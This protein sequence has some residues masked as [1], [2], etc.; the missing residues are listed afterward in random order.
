MSQI[1]DILKH[2]CYNIKKFEIKRSNVL[3]LCFQQCFKLSAFGNNRRVR[4]ATDTLQGIYAAKN[5]KRQQ[6]YRVYILLAFFCKR[7]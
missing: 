6:A 7:G 1:V 2:D 4:S 5:M 3:F